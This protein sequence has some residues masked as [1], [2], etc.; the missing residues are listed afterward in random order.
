[1]WSVVLP[2]TGFVL[3]ITGLRL[4]DHFGNPSTVAGIQ[5]NNDAGAA[6]FLLIGAVD[7]VLGA[8]SITLGVGVVRRAR[9]AAVDRR[10]LAVVGITLGAIV[11]LGGFVALALG[12][13]LRSLNSLTF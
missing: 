1:M 5:Q 12:L 7:V 13:F 11:V 6:A 4:S 3:S 2:V 8:V 10:E 9:V